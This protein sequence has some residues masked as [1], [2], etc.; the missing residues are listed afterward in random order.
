MTVGIGS[1][2][3]EYRMIMDTAS[4]IIW[5]Q[6]EG[7][8]ICFPQSAP[9]FDPLNS[10]TNQK[11]ECCTSLFDTVDRDCEETCNY[12]ADYEDHSTSYDVFS[13]VTFTFETSNEGTFVT[14]PN[15]AFGCGEENEGVFAREVAGIVGVGRSSLS[16]INQLGDNINHKFSYCL[17][18]QGTNTLVFGTPAHMPVLNLKSTPLLFLPNDPIYYILDLQDITVGITRLRIPQGSFD[19]TDEQ[20]S[21]IIDS[22]TAYTYLHRLAYDRLSQSLDRAIRLQKVV[23]SGINLQLCY[24]VQNNLDFQRIP[25]VTFHFSGNNGDWKVGPRTLFVPMAPG[26][27]LQ[28]ILPDIHGSVFGALIQGDMFV[29]K[30]VPPSRVTAINSPFSLWCIQDFN[31]HTF[32]ML[33]LLL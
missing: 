29:E 8:T 23:V 16:L 7:C 11:V 30:T 26:A 24:R 28:G 21:L 1:P 33:H 25:A 9:L 31:H 18:E 15:V 2:K 17:P 10:D 13:T 12:A 6:C 14:V 4:S 19:P 27:V 5:T 3:I 20:R 32:I 22:G